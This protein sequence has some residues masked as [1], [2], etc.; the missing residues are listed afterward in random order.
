MTIFDIAKNISQEKERL[1]ISSLD[2]IYS[3]F[4]INRIMA[5]SPDLVFLASEITKI[6][7]VDN[8]THYDLWFNVV[9]KRKRYFKYHKEEKID[10]SQIG[11]IQ[12]YFGINQELAIEYLNILSDEEL[13]YINE[14]FKHGTR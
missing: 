11:N 14:S 10:N 1:D 2:K 13:V 6:K 8:Q 7:E 4:M 12:T 3:Q 9:T 5:C